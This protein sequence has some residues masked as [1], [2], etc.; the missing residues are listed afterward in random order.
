[1]HACT[2]LDCEKQAPQ[3]AAEDAAGAAI[4]SELTQPAP[5]PYTAPKPVRYLPTR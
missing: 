2:L 4:Q 1:M 3:T 5:P